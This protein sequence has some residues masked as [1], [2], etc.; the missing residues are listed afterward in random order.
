MPVYPS[1]KNIQ[2]KSRP[3]NT[4]PKSQLAQRPAPL[5]AQPVVSTLPYYPAK[6][7]QKRY[8]KK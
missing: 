3:V 5:K 4:K 1:T 8:K 2:V 6:M 7:A